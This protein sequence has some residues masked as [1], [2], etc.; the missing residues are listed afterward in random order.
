[1]RRQDFSYEL[2]K[3]LIANLPLENRSDSRLM[4]IDPVRPIAHQTVSD[5]PSM[6]REGDVVVANNTRV[7]PARLFGKRYRAVES[8]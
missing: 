4:V 3:Q 1:M 2:P 6:I 5:L 7:F 8:R